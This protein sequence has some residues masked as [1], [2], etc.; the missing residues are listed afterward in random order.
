MPGAAGEGAAPA[1]SRVP[2]P[3]APGKLSSAL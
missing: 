1:V 2:V 3:A